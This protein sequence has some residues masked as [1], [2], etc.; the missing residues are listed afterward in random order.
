MLAAT[1]VAWR[2]VRKSPARSALIAAL[3]ALPV[4][5]GTLA[6]VLYRTQ[7][8][9]PDQQAQRLIG[10][11]DAVVLATKWSAVN[12]FAAVGRDVNDVG[13]QTF[14]WGRGKG[15]VK[16]DA[17]AVDVEQLLPTSARAVPAGWKTDVRVTA[18]QRSVVSTAML[19]DLTDPLS[20]G[21]VELD[22][23]AAPRAAGDVVL[24]KH[25][26]DRL[27]VGVGADV[28]LRSG[29]R[30]HVTGLGTDPSNLDADTVVGTP[31]T[32]PLSMFR[33]SLY[34]AGSFTWLVD[35]PGPAPALHDEL[36][37][38]G[39]VYATRTQ[40]EHPSVELSA[41]TP[42][43]TQIIAILTGIA[44]FGLLEIILLAGTA[45]A[46]G[47]RRQV[48]ELGTLLAAGG[49]DRDVRRVLLAQG[50]LLG[51]AGA[52]IGT[53]LGVLA[54]WL[55]QPVFEDYL[56][57]AL[58]PFDVH[59]LDVVAVL[60][61][62]V[63]AGLLAAIVPA[64]SAAR[65][66]VV[67]MLR[68]RFTTDP[69]MRRTPRWAW[70]ALAVGP[71]VVVGGA[72]FWHHAR[73]LRLDQSS[74]AAFIR[75]LTSST[76]DTLWTSVIIVGT[77]ITLAGL[78]RLC[79]QL[80]HLLSGRSARLGLSTRL[81]LRDATRHHHRTAPAVAAVMTVLAGS[82]LVLFTVSSIDLRARHAYLPVAPV[83]TV[84]VSAGSSL[85]RTAAA[86]QQVVAAVGDA[87]SVQVDRAVPGPQSPRRELAPVLPRCNPHRN[88][89]IVGDVSVG[90][91]ALVDFYAGKTVPGAAAMLARGGAVV[92]DP[93]FSGQQSIRIAES[94][95]F[96][97]PVGAV[98]LPMLMTDGPIYNFRP[99]VV[100][101]A[102][103]ARSHGWT[104]LADRGLVTPRH[105]VSQD[106]EDRL[107][108]ALGAHS[109]VSVERG[110]QGDYGPIAL[111]LIAAS[112]LAALGGTSIA[113]ALAMAES[114]A[115]SA[116]LAA[117]GAP[118]AQRRRYAMA[119]AATIG[120][121]GAALGLGLGL[122]VSVSLFEGS[123]SYPTSVPYRWL[124]VLV[125]AA[126]VLAAA[127]AGLV[128]R[129]R[130]PMTRR[131]A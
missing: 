128:T 31:S 61:L 70:A 130:V 87:T 12:R 41:K 77:A 21:I 85:A 79:P 69:A 82:V 48:R 124:A 30:L 112:A 102:G 81:A 22:E 72:G 76:H 44:G 83:G 29:R 53:G 38:K 67:D 8:L 89:C 55:G 113:V 43:D 19:L 122:L 73:A 96:G 42:V 62:G 88:V 103:T 20:R 27:H 95:R 91:A 16:R 32:F 74:A 34:G 108:H 25:L 126:P 3:V 115:D 90:T 92:F 60:A 68:A 54:A 93:T 121:L 15:A 51:A 80:L 36:V 9:S 18:G 107:N 78:I 28:S 64:R 123:T 35:F 17:T 37:G 5:A 118:P 101:S 131:I 52:V 46:V 106:T 50:L 66:S 86:T 33:S 120:G 119:Q 84:T 100:V 129:G 2:L 114:R 104:V 1:R 49:D 65:L 57:R 7:Q 6:G 127:V 98:T 45:F 4:L 14:Q 58:G 75:S 56:G 26:A 39:V 110:Y 59:A 40:W 47:A 125:L 97:R 99:F 24:S 117:V 10:S 23:G 111:I 13:Y 63:V 71:L 11:A 109:Y 116:T 94:G 105:G